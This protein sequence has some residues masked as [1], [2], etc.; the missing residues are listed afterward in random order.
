MLSASVIAR[1]GALLIAG[2]FALGVAH[3]VVVLVRKTAREQ[4]LIQRSPWRRRH[5]SRALRAAAVVEACTAVALVLVPT[6]GLAASS[7]LLLLYTLE[8]TKL[9]P[10]ETCGCFGHV[11]DAASR[12]EAILRNLVLAT[13][14][15]GILAYC[16]ATGTRVGP[17]SQRSLGAALLAFSFATSLLALRS[18]MTNYAPARREG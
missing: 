8:L 1:V 12:Y 5:A 16:A 13:L 10:D 3:K 4:A 6:A 15:A 14:A 18:T 2:V 7:C 17:L 11:F 9:R